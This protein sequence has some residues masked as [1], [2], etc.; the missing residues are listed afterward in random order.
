MDQDEHA[1]RLPVRL[2]IG[3]TG[4]RELPPDPMLVERVREV[5]N[6]IRHALPASD[7]TP[8]QLGV[9]S[10]LAEGADRLVAREVLASEGALLE[11]PLPLPRDEYLR[12]F[13]S[14]RSREEFA[15]LLGRASFVTVVPDMGAPEEIYAEAGRLVVDRCDALVAVWDG[16]PSRGVG[17]TADAVA[18]ARDRRV[19]LYWIRAGD[20]GY[21]IVEEPGNGFPESRFR[22]VDAY[23]RAPVPSHGLTARVDAETGRL[24]AEAER[25]G[26]ATDVVE[27]ALA[28]YLPFL[29]RADALSL[30]LQRRYYRL[31]MALFVLA[32]L[33]AVAG[34][35]TSALEWRG[36]PVYLKVLLLLVHT[37]LSVDTRRREL[38][39]RWISCRLL[40]EQLRAAMFLTVA[41]LEASKDRA[42]LVDPSLSW[43]QAASTEVCLRS[44][45]GAPP[46][47]AAGVLRRFLL[48]AWVD[49]QLGYLRRTGERQRRRDGRLNTAV[50]W[51]FGGTLALTVAEAFQGQRGQKPGVALT[52]ALTGLPALA[53]AFSGIREQRQYVRNSERSLRVAGRLERLRTR[54]VAAR[55]L[56]AVQELATA[57]AILLSEENQDWFGVMGAGNL[58]PAP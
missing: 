10:P 13:A 31:G 27:P 16:A 18:H 19:P 50:S 17:G 49:Q 1:G 29:A 51:L 30:G 54:L 43:V 47:A 26:L 8:V 4:H 42:D 14:Q 9:V 40:A 55:D 12:D 2:W 36:R 34:W 46:A 3:V 37:F 23:N 57:T 22:Q 35:A 11:V 6:R 25:V 52:L 45:R 58:K 56:G 38:P 28:W 15:E 39:A 48:G 5:L 7:A 44:P 41:G 20:A 21:E 32:A 24:R 53:A 33:A